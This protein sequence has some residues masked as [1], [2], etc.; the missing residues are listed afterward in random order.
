MKIR[1]TEKNVLSFMKM[2]IRIICTQTRRAPVME[3]T[4]YCHDTKNKSTFS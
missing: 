1:A 2:F 4:D 3:G